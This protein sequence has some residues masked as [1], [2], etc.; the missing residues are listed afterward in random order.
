MKNHLNAQKLRY[1]IGQI[2]DKWILA[3]DDPNEWKQA[4]AKKN[5]HFVAYEIKKL[6]GVRYLWVFLVILLLLNSATAWY[7]ASRSSAAQEPAQMIA[8]FFDLYFANPEECDAHY[9]KMKAFQEEQNALMHEAFRNGDYD[10]QTE[11]MPDVY[12]T[13]ENYPDAILFRTLYDAVDAAKGYPALLQS[14]MDSARAN[15]AEFSVMGIHENSFTYKYQLRVIALYELAQ[16]N[17]K[18]GVE[19]TRGWDE[20][21]SYDL[22]NVFLSVMIIML[23]TLVFAQEK[24]SGFMPIIRTARHGRLRTA[25]AK[26]L[27][28]LLLSSVFVLL[29][30]MS[31]WA[32]YGIR[33]GFSSPHNVLQALDTF[34]LSPYRITVGEYFV[35]TIGVRLLSFAVFSVIILTLSTLLYNYILI[36]LTGLGFYGLNFLLYSLKYINGSSPAKNLNLVA[37]SAVNPLFVRY[38]AVNL[39][40]HVA[41]YVPF[42]LCVMTVLLVGCSVLTAWMYVRGVQEVRPLWLDSLLSAVMTKKAALVSAWRRIFIYRIPL[43]RAKAGSVRRRSYSLSLTAAESFK[44]LISSRFIFVLAVLL[45]IKVWYASD[46]YAASRSYADDVYKEYMTILEGPVTEEKLAYIAEERASI[47]ETIAKQAQM[48]Q[49]YANGEID[50]DEYKAYLSAYNYAYSRNELFSG[51]EEHAAYLIRQKEQTGID[52]WFV[53]D[54][55]WRKLYTEDADLFLYTSILLLLTGTFASEYAS[56]SSSGGFAQILRSTRNGRE[57]TFAA[58][59]ISAGMIAVIL[60]GFMGAVDVVTVFTQYEMPAADAPLLSMQIFASVGYNI[61]VAGYLALFLLLRVIGAVLM[62]M[63]VC[64][65]S[66]LLCRYIPVLGSAVILTLLPAL[67]AAFGLAAAERVNFLNLLAGTPLVLQSMDTGF[68]SGWAMLALW[69]AAAG[70]AVGAMMISARRMFVK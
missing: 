44:T 66:E 63:L 62:A 27:T 6:F 23:G 9:A 12:S 50:F 56:K 21:F 64:A 19:Y 39:F 20:Y 59:L 17:V 46:T 54:T 70:A 18:I 26:I 13:D 36:Y 38:R 10:F 11:R 40:G 69:I 47:S 31:T 25:C 14:V 51:I 15:L 58:K 29:F 1:G 7:T 68:F 53:Y 16:K 61:P 33:I 32:V 30:T 67:C 41:G 48:Q 8:D 28:M 49:A 52:G 60:A 57:K 22:V 4:G 3:A 37:V 2:D 42:M 55:G 35:M 45:C 65:L 5:R 34:A 43:K 24:Q